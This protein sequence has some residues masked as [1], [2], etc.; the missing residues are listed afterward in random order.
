MPTEMTFLQQIGSC[1]WLLA[2]WVELAVLVLIVYLV[3]KNQYRKIARRCN[4][5]RSRRNP[6]RVPLAS[7]ET[8]RLSHLS[9]DWFKEGELR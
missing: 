3:D 1:L 4:Q 5:A 7:A 8:P 6:A 9:V 2:L